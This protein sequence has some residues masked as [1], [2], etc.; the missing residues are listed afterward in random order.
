MMEKG[1]TDRSVEHAGATNKHN[2]VEGTARTDWTV[3]VWG[4]FRMLP[5]SQAPAVQSVPV[6]SESCDNVEFKRVK[7]YITL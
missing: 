1:T 4:R 7:T 2:C 6:L 3:E 5:L